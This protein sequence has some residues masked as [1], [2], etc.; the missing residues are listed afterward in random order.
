MSSTDGS[1]SRGLRGFR[2]ERAEVSEEAR[3]AIAAVDR[4]RMVASKLRECKKEGR[5]S[6]WFSTISV[7]QGM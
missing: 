3:R 7:K 4:K 2:S 5:R 1:A 6:C